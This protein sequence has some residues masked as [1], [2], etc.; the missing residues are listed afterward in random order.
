MTTEKL[1]KAKRLN[2]EMQKLQADIDFL[3][4]AT[5]IKGIAEGVREYQAVLTIGKP[6]DE[7][8]MVGI[9]I[10]SE[11]SPMIFKDIVVKKTKWLTDQLDKLKKEFA[12]L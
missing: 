9:K 12:K 1:E 2:W 10:P 3:K 6:E 4:E 11:L 5:T 7:N 8:P